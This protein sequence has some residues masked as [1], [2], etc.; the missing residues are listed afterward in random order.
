MK[1]LIL[2][3]E[4]FAADKL[5]RMLHE[6]EPDV[7]IMAQLQS[8]ESATDWLKQ[9]P[10]PD[11]IISDIRL[12]DGLCF[13]IFQEVRI[14]CPVIFC[15][16]YDQYAIRAFEVH[17]ID[18][19]LKPVQPEKLA[20]SL[21][22]LK[23]ITRGAPLPPFQEMLSYLKTSQPEYKSRF[24][25]RIGQRIMAIPVQTI[26]YFYSESKLTFIFTSDG[27][28]YPL[29]QPLNELEHQLD[30]REFFKINRQIIVKFNAI[31]EIH[32]YFKGRV[33][34]KLNPDLPE[35]II[36]SAERSPEFKKWL[37]Q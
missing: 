27:K 9:N 13:Q 26:A 12:L 6:L 29:D 15:T 33:K 5:N 32:P 22:K 7:Q 25:V 20:Q 24:M 14:T 28:K 21:N 19:L 16:A 35:E 4:I 23:S 17:S 18:Y 37:D 10:S 1:I 11:V 8:V 30:P 2:E 34:L 3:D 36:V 31:A